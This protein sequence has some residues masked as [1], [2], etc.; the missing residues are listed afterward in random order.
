MPAR[1]YQT[2]TTGLAEHKESRVCSMQT[3][4]VIED[5]RGTA[6]ER[7]RE[8]DDDDIITRGREGGMI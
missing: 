7:E 3:V 5:N 2:T 6:K 4:V 1:A 8:S